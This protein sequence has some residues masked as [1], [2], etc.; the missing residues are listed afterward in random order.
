L[1][2]AGPEVAPVAAREPNGRATRCAA[3][4][5]ASDLL[6]IAEPIDLSGLCAP[7]D[8]WALFDRA[9]A[10]A[11][12][13]AGLPTCVLPASAAPQTGEPLHLILAALVAPHHGAAATLAR[14]PAALA[15]ELAAVESAKVQHFAYR[16][17]LDPELIRHLV[18]CIT[19]QDGCS[20]Q[21]APCLVQQEAEAMGMH[22]P[23]SA[24]YVVDCLADTLLAADDETLE[25]LGPTPIGEAFLAQE[26]MRHAPEQQAAIVDRALRRD[27]AATTAVLRRV[28]ELHN[29]N[30]RNH[31][32]AGW[33]CQAGA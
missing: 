11:T 18:A 24:E 10:M 31:P 2:P 22:L 33:S 6:E 12:R 3:S 27:R 29:D 16:Q 1:L 25:P 4:I 26:L 5:S 20:L 23:E 13:F 14:S 32:A 9:M 7:A 15:G 28:A 8:R 17:R 30:D 21:A 19:L